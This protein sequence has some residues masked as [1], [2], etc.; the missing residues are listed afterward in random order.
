VITDRENTIRFE[1]PPSEAG[2]VL[3]THPLVSGK[4]IQNNFVIDYT[5]DSDD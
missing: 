4:L 5:I 2:K 3:L 1:I